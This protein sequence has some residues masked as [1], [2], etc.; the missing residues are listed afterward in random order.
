MKTRVLALLVALLFTFV[1]AGSAFAAHEAKEV[2]GTITKI[3]PVEY[4]VTLK[5]EKGM[6]VKVR[7][8]D[9]KDLKAGD[10]ALV[11]NGKLEKAVK[12][13]TGGY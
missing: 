8:K 1:L 5:D 13:I 4:E 11:K 12:P 3:Q 9:L 6:E 7:V 2:K 10:S